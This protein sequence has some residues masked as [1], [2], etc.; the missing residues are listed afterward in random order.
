M[1]DIWT[2]RQKVSVI[3]FT[4][5]YEKDWKICQSTLGFKEFSDSHTAENIK[6][7]IST[8]TADNASNIL[9]AF[10]IK[11]IDVDEDDEN[12][13]WFHQ[14]DEEN[15]DESL[16]NVQNC[17]F[18]SA[19]P[20]NS[21]LAHLLQL[22]IRDAIS[23]NDFVVSLIKDVNGIVRFF[24]KST[25]YYSKLKKINGDLS[26]IKP[27][28]TRWNSQYHCL[29]RICTH[30]KNKEP[31]ISSI[32]QIL[33]EAKAEK[34]S[35]KGKIPKCITKE[36]EEMMF[37]ILK[38]LQPFANLTDALQGDDVTSSLV[39]PGLLDA[40]KD[41]DN[42]VFTKHES[43]LLGFKASLVTS[44]VQRFT[45]NKDRGE[46]ILNADGKTRNIVTIDAMS[47]KA[48]ILAAVLDPRIKTL[49]FQGHAN[50]TPFEQKFPTRDNVIDMLKNEMMEHYIS[51]VE[52]EQEATAA[53]VKKS[54]N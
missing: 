21:C 44:V 2:S 36:M 47:S 11:D 19:L 5:Q 53:P 34:K 14:P 43:Q 1:L 46:R 31:M 41:A 8:I 25:H 51:T 49:P 40:V 42:H 48:Y 37:E 26:L 38:L 39:I 3:G 28:T 22:A 13:Q 12:S 45:T 9:S 10:K 27:C 30:G 29:K 7:K 52:V 18:P 15:E 24:H 32:N 23:E 6:I 33:K 16:P 35:G 50:G 20:R 17:G 4:A 54:Q